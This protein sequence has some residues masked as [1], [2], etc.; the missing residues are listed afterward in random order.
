MSFDAAWRATDG[1]SS[2]LFGWSSPDA[3]QRGRELIGLRVVDV[4]YRQ[5]GLARHP[6]TL[7]FDSGWRL[8]IFHDFAVPQ[9]YGL[10][11]TRGLF[12]RRNR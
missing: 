6:E 8:E 3:A 12:R 9:G 10:S 5:D 7:V 4:T 11:M 2:T 1:S